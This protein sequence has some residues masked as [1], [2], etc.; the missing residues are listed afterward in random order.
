MVGQRRPCS[1]R[2]KSR[3]CAI[4]NCEED[5]RKALAELKILSENNED[6][7]RLLKHHPDTGL[8][9]PHVLTRRL[10]SRIQEKPEEHFAFGII[11]LDQWYQ[12]IRHYRDRQKALLFVTAQRIMNLV[13]EEFLFQ[14]D[15]ADEFLVI[16][17]KVKNEED[18][19]PFFNRL[20]ESIS[21]PHSGPI[22]DV[23]FGCHI[24]VALYPQHADSVEGLFRNA[25][26]ALGIYEKRQDQ[27]FF[28]THE[29]GEAHLHHRK[30][31]QALC[32]A[33]N[34]G[35][36][37]FHIAY[38]PVVDRER[39]TIAC[40]ALLRWDTTDFGLVS[41]L[42]FIPMAEEN[43]QINIL[44]Q[45]IL[46][47]SLCQVRDW[48]KQTSP[49][50]AV[51]VNV[52]A[53]Q[54]EHVNYLENVGGVLEALGISGNSL[55]IEVTESTLMEK[56]RGIITKLE[57]LRSMGV[58]I[59]LDD[60]G[61][62]YSS[63]SALFQLPVD[64]LKIAKEFV[65]HITTNPRALEMIR[66]ILQ[67]AHSCGLETLAEGV[68][69]EEQYELLLGEGCNYIQGYLVSPPVPAAEFGEFLRNNDTLPVK[70]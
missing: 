9:L 49:A 45:W 51:S 17:P 62:G 34:Q 37:E 27:G 55:R 61:T 16:L 56:P 67:M 59:M 38:Q 36:E 57:V 40:E 20:N 48:H 11:R 70:P 50:I 63:L 64:I 60:F 21:A 24:G 5:L 26:I 4:Q 42:E 47:N 14:S 52:S 69:T 28:Y 25:E 54:L 46:Y 35:L 68:E 22:M 30:M 15:R 53:V 10:M 2:L 29:L 65:D 13:G 32:S 39:K 41:P 23:T 12:K 3:S 19:L 43:G 1:H 33:I 8:L 58:K 7:N 6:L 44:G 66:A 31:E 18:V